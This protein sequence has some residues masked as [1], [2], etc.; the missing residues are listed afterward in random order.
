VLGF[1]TGVGRIVQEICIRE[2]VLYRVLST[3][4]FL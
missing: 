4:S 2:N 3:M 1:F